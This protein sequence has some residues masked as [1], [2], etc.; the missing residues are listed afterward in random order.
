MERLFSAKREKSDRNAFGSSFGCWRAGIGR[1][2]TD[3]PGSWRQSALAAH[4]SAIA[5]QDATPAAHRIVMEK[6]FGTQ[7]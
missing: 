3:R 7:K 4:N 2:R 1:V 6:L 5:Q